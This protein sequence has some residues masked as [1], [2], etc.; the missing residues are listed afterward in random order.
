MA[1]SSNTYFAPSWGDLDKEEKREWKDSGGTKQTYNEEHGLGKYEGTTPDIE[2]YDTT[3]YGSGSEKDKDKLSRA[4]LLNLEKQGYTREEIAKY[5]ADMV[6]SG[7]AQGEK[8]EALLASWLANGGEKPEEPQEPEKPEEPIY[9]IQPSPRDAFDDIEVGNGGD[10]DEG[11]SNSGGDDGDSGNGNTGGNNG[12]NNTGVIGSVIGDGSVVNVGDGN[13][14]VGGNNTVEN[15]FN[16]DKEFRFDSGGGDIYN[17]GN[18]NSDLS[19]NFN[20]FNAFNASTGGSTDPTLDALDAAL[21]F[22]AMG[23]SGQVAPGATG[24]SP[25]VGDFTGLIPKPTNI[26]LGAA[27]LA[28]ANRLD[29]QMRGDLIFNHMFGERW[30]MFS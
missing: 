22:N 29:A 28:E 16:T 26:A 8:A 21:A 14:G 30:P 3:G 4:D 27:G 1:T 19:T 10:G 9:E 25:V 15:N 13:A 11:D 18:L 24:I 7:T 2:N 17:Y 6:E 5:S 20:N 12:D 23:Q